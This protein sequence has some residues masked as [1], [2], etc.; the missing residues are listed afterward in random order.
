MSSVYCVQFG[1]GDT[2]LSPKA[3]PDALPTVCDETLLPPTGE[4]SPLHTYQPRAVARVFPI[5]TLRTVVLRSWSDL[6]CTRLP[7]RARRIVCRLKPV[8]CSRNASEIC[9]IR[10]RSLSLKTPFSWYRTS[11]GSSVL[12]SSACSQPRSVSFPIKWNPEAVTGYRFNSPWLS[13][14]QGLSSGAR[15]LYSG[16]RW[17]CEN[18]IA[19][20]CGRASSVGGLSVC[21]EPS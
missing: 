7:W 4:R 1:L 11:A 8:S 14:L 5:G 19:N 10:C 18:T 15:L 12:M 16:C 21:V 20:V 6:G 3:K 13:A 17:Y 9:P 2:E